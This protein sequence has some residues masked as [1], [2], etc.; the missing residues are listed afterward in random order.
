METD[1]ACACYFGPNYTLICS[2]C[3]DKESLEA[4]NTS[5]DRK[6]AIQATKDKKQNG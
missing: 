6:A 4:A 1:T 2:K 3:K 5:C